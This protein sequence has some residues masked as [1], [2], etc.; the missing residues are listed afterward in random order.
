M[1]ADKVITER[2]LNVLRPYASNWSGTLSRGDLVIPQSE[3]PRLI[4]EVLTVAHEIAERHGEAGDL[5]V[6]QALMSGRASPSI[7]DQV[8]DLK[9]RFLILAR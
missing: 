8:A 6:F 4:R 9:R 3:V 2:I 7:Q 5:E 1:S